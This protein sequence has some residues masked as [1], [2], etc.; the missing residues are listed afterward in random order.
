MLYKSR[1]PT[2]LN[3]K[4]RNMYKIVLFYSAL[5]KNLCC[6]YVCVCVCNYLI[7]Y[8]LCNYFINLRLFVPQFIYLFMYLFVK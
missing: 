4:D 5:F 2:K 1:Q 3:M 8:F 7:N 6:V